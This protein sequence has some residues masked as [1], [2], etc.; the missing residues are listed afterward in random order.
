MQGLWLVGAADAYRQV[1]KALIATS[2]KL[3][4]PELG[5]WGQ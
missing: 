1:S 3:S 5:S 2:S 4:G